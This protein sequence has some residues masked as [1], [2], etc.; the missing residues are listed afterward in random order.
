[1]KSLMR[2]AGLPE[3]TFDVLR[4]RDE[5]EGLVRMLQQHL[6]AGPGLRERLRRWAAEEAEHSWEN[7]VWLRR[8]ATGADPTSR[9]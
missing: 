8:H 9:L 3:D 6:E 4:L 1:M 7:V 2:S 5:S